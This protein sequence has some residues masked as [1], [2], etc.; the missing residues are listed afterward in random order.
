MLHV[1]ADAARLNALCQDHDKF[2]Q[3]ADLCIQER[4]AAGKQTAPLQT[5]TGKLGKSTAAVGRCL[6]SATRRRQ[7]TN[8]ADMK[9]RMPEIC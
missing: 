6:Q 4:A 7:R 8:A 5:F 2:M 3:Y 1:Q 9:P